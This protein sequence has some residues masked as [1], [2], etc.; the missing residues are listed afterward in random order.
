[1]DTIIHQTALR[2]LEADYVSSKNAVSSVGAEKAGSTC[3]YVAIGQKRSSVAQLAKKLEEVNAMPW[4]VIIAATASDSAPLQFLAPYAGCTI[5]EYFRDIG[6]PT[7]IIYDDLSKQAVAY[8]QLSLLLRRPPGREAYPGD[9]FYCHSRLLERAANMGKGYSLTALPIIETQAG[10]LSAGRECAREFLN[11]SPFWYRR[12]DPNAAHDSGIRAGFWVGPTMHRITKV[13]HFKADERG[14]SGKRTASSLATCTPTH[15]LWGYATRCASNAGQ[16]DNETNHN[17]VHCAKVGNGTSNAIKTGNTGTFDMPKTNNF[18]RS[19]VR[20][21]DRKYATSCTNEASCT[22]MICQGPQPDRFMKFATLALIKIRKIDWNEFYI[23]DLATALAKVE[24]YSKLAKEEKDYLGRLDLI[25]IVGNPTYLLYSYSLIRK[26]G[27]VGIDNI[28]PTGL[29]GPSIIKL[30]GELRVGTYK[31]KPTKRVMIPKADKK[32]LRPLGIASTRDKVVQQA[33]KMVLEPLF[34]PIFHPRSHGFRPKKS[35]HSALKEIE[36]FWPNTIW[37]LEFDFKQAFDS[38]NHRFV[39]AQVANRFADKPFLA[40]LWKMLKVGY[41][42]PLA[43]TDSKLELTEGTPQGS[44]ISPLMSNIYFHRLDEWIQEELIPRYSNPKQAYTK[45]NE[46][47]LE[48]T[49]RWKGN[50]WATVL[51]TVRPLT[52]NL[53]APKRR[54]FLRTL[55]VEE[56][57]AL[58]IPYYSKTNRNRLTYSRYADDFLLGYRGTKQEAREILGEIL[59]FCES[60]L[61]MGVNPEKTGI[62]HK[63]DGVIYLGYKIWLDK[64]MTVGNSGQRT[65]RTR[66]KFSVPLEK[67]YKKYAE[68]GF[69]KKAKR[70]SAIRYVAKKQDKY[71]FMEPY[72]IVQRYN[73]VARGLINYYSGSERLSHLYRLLYDL[74]RSAALTLAHSKKRRSASWAFDKWGSDLTVQSSDKVTKFYLPSLEKKKERWGKGDVNEISRMT[75]QGFAYPKSLSFVKS[76]S[77]LECAIPK[78]SNQAS[79]WHH[80][81]HRRKIGGKGLKRQFVLAAARQIPVCKMHHSQIHNGRYDGPNL[82]GIKG[83]EI[84]DDSSV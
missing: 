6:E 47:Y 29:T 75:I 48:A 60:T 32:K 79:D 18:G 30:A 72:Y 68:K 69:L 39:M 70:N 59:N 44:I 78:C 73:S 1:M 35:C 57:K 25:E 17:E 38:V 12:E 8:R 20:V 82:R 42:H 28:L 58:N 53:D 55:R 77:E 51:D 63:E 76:A 54:R 64:E 61:K 7:V 33:V 74:R 81:N 84:D 49:D 27:A 37:L 23:Y 65:T 83:Y 21:A 10:D 52:P 67:L 66:M 13:T 50:E 4:T 40:L 11:Y 15:A 3:V 56:A 41:V 62:A 19:A 16:R 14:P 31:P 9:V 26:D 24:Y 43:L 71:M 36:L 5:A 80:I 22:A 34:E 45:I 46:D 2:Q